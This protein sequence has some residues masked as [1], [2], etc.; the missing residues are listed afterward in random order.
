MVDVRFKNCKITDSR[1]KELQGNELVMEGTTLEERT[2]LAWSSI[3]M[4]FRKCTLDGVGLSG[5]KAPVAMTI[6]DSLM[7]EVDL[8]RGVFSTVTLRRVKQGEGP[9]RFNGATMERITIED[10]DLWRGLSLSEIKAGSV[11]IEGGKLKTSFSDS[12]IPKVYA[13]N[14]EFYLFSLSE[15]NLPFV[16]LTDCKIHDFPMWDG[17]T[18]E[19]HLHNCVINEVDGENFKADTVIWDNVTLD[20]K[21]DFTNAQVKD[22][23]ATRLKRGP[24]LELFTTGS[25]LKF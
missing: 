14:V 8:G 9:V 6:E 21:I 17:Y 18:E 4:A 22:F 11:S 2:S 12:I 20:G 24:K 1:M 23:Q 19:L 3:P 15:S 5:M 7:D 13:R 25:N 16:S 10:V